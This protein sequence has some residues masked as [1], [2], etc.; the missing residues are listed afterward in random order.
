MGAHELGTKESVDI[1]SIWPDEEQ[2]F[3]PW[4]AANIGYLENEVAGIGSDLEVVESESRVGSYTADLRVTDGSEREIV[5]EN[6]LTDADHKHLGQILLYAA[7]L[8]AD[9][10]IWLAPSFDDE[11]LEVFQWLNDGDDGVEFF[12][13]EMNAIRIG[14]SKPALE[15]TVVEQPPKSVVKTSSTQ[16]SETGELQ[17]QFWQTFEEYARA[18]SAKH[19][20]EGNPRPGAA[21]HPINTTW[22]EL[23][24]SANTRDERL[25]CVM[26]IKD[27]DA[28]FR[29]LEEG[30]EEL[31][32]K[33][34][35]QYPKLPDPALDAETLETINWESHNDQLRDLIEMDF[36]R[37]FV[38]K[39]RE[40]WEDYFDWLIDA[41]ELFYRVFV[42]ELGR[43]A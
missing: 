39:D 15:F 35:E 1:R 38:L 33:L 6:Q 27:E 26:R 9:T 36:P 4:L 5:I 25:Y 18:N 21:Y 3:T 13:I 42:P 41:G 29:G 12:A 37:R 43:G 22:G 14:D 11:Y 23:R 32:K 20:A 34:R 10:S 7:G 31:M 8:D 19:L 16:V 24:F 2:D 40:Q 17:Q 30:K 28:E